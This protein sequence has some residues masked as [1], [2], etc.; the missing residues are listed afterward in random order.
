MSL[1]N[2]FRKNREMWTEVE[3]IF[4]SICDLLN[5]RRGYGAYQKDL[6][7]DAY[8]N[9]SSNNQL[10]KQIVLDIKNCIGRYEKRVVVTEVLSV[11]NNNI[12]LLSFLIKCKV[13][14]KSHEFHLSFNCQKNCFSG[15]PSE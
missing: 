9:L 8:L 10:A 6:G 4:E 15:G 11:S 3:E 5:T 7:L 13:R 2:H 1:L 14:D 12:F